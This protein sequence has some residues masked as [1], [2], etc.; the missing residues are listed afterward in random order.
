[1]SSTETATTKPIAKE[2]A[3]TLTASTATRIA[4]RARRIWA[5][6]DHAQ[7]RSFEI[8][9]GVPIESRHV[10]RANRDTVEQLERLYRM[11]AA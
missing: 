5:E 4:R 1:V 10:H 2:P 3:M 9:T 6:L 8:R 11:R 7:R